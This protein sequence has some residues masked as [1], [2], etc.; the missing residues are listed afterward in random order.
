[1]SIRLLVVL[2][3]PA[4][5]AVSGCTTTTSCG[6]RRRLLTVAYRHGWGKGA[7]QAGSDKVAWGRRG[8]GSGW[9]HRRPGRGTA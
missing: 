6:A 9:R 8:S 2:H 4:T 1:M 7:S 5:A 3:L